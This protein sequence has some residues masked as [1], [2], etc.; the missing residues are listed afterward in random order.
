MHRLIPFTEDIK[1]MY[2][3]LNDMQDEC[4]GKLSE[5]PSAKA[6]IDLAKVCLTQMILFNRRREGEVASMPL[7]A[8]L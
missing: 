1:K 5:C 8:F 3:F 4:S 2:Q 6:W 7:F